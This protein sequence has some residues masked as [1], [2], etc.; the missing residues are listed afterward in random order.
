MASLKLAAKRSLRMA[1]NLEYLANDPNYARICLA[2]IEEAAND[3][4]LLILVMRLRE[5][6]LAPEEEKPMTE[7]PAPAPTETAEKPAD[8]ML[9]TC[10]FGA[11]SG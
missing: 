11:R 4:D 2:E 9:R 6:L 7:T 5:L 3:E 8:E 1:V 10:R